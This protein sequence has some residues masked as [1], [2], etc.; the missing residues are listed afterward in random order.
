MRTG[1]LG[2]AALVMGIVVAMAQ[3]ADSVNGQENVSS[4]V[5]AYAFMTA[6][7]FA[8]LLKQGW[9]AATGGQNVLSSKAGRDHITSLTLLV[10]SCNS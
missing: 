2:F 6:G 3:P 8:G 7:G 4:G 1:R 9:K 10:E 5:S